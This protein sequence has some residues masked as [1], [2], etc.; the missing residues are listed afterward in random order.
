MVGEVSHQDRP[1]AEQQGDGARREGARERPQQGARQFGRDQRQRQGS[2]GQGDLL[3]SAARPPPSGR[4]ASFAPP[5][6]GGFAFVQDLGDYSSVEDR[7]AG[8]FTEVPS[9]TVTPYSDT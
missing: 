8:L 4:P 5:P 2:F 1:A 9:P 6:R 3:L 7:T